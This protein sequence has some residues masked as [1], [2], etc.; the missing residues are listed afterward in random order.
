MIIR[1]GYPGV[2]FG[3]P[4]VPIADPLTSAAN[5]LL[6]YLQQNPAP[7]VPFGAC[8]VFQ[9]AWN[10]SGRSPAIQIDGEYGPCSQW[11]LSVVLGHA[12]AQAFGGSCVNG[13]YVP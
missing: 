8:R 10:N 3:R 5:A 11:A 7:A 9:V 1:G 4:L 6:A 12:P 13:Q 2:I